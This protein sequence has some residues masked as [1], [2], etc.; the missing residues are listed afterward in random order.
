[1]SQQEASADVTFASEKEDAKFCCEKC[2]K[3]YS[4]KRALDLH[5]KGA[6]NIKTITYT[7][8]P[9]TSKT[10]LE[11]KTRLSLKCD[12]CTFVCK[13]NP[14]MNK[15]LEM[16]HKTITGQERPEVKKRQMKTFTCPS[17]NSTF[18]SNYR[19][20]NH[21]KEQHEGKTSYPQR[22]RLQGQKTRRRRRNL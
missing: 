13:S 21:M 22:E 16:H 18:V 6:H 5:M 10:K 1:M 4:K 19:M 3:E 2:G 9:V 15:H 17:C 8:G 20:R 14:S 12:L 11:T 7:P